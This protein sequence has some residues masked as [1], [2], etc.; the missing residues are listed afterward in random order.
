MYKILDFVLH[1]VLKPILFLLYIPLVPFFFLLDRLQAKQCPY[2]GEG[3][4]TELVGEWDGEDWKCHR[5][6]Q[7]W[8]VLNDGTVRKNKEYIDYK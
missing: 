7:Y 3:W 2:C 6:R 5:C 1:Y 8:S 4:Y